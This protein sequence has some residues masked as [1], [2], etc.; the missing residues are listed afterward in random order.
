M[1]L[2]LRRVSSRTVTDLT[3]THSGRWF[4]SHPSNPSWVYPTDTYGP[5]RVYVCVPRLL[6]WYLHPLTSGRNPGSGFWSSRLLS[7]G[8]S[9]LVTPGL[10]VSWFTDDWFLW[11]RP[12]SS[13]PDW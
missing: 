7:S 4:G 2:R 12:P 1:Y 5:S 9:T 10:G 13:H 3:V 8:A 11:V 6:V